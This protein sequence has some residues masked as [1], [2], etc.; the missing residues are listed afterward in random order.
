[1]KTNQSR[2]YVA[3]LVL[4]T[5]IIT[6]YVKHRNKKQAEEARQEQV[7]R[8]AERAIKAR[9]DRYRNS[10]TGRRDPSRPPSDEPTRIPGFDRN[11]PGQLIFTKHARCRMGCRH[12][13]ADEVREILQNGRINERKS[14]PAAR[15]DPKYALEGRTRDGQEVRIIF[16]PSDRGMV[17]IT[18]IDL[19]TDWPCDCK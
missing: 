17:V 7:I 13:D 6:V 1:M 15:P 3:L 18:V 5:L 9:Q 11:R 10:D 19:D 14:E 2:I 16:A 4:A 8:Q 12:I